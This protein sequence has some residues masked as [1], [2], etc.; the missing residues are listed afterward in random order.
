M[1]A[2]RASVSVDGGAMPVPEIATLDGGLRVVA[3]PMPHARSVAISIY[4]NAGARYEASDADAGLS[5]FLEHLCF[6]G[7]PRRPTPRDVAIEIDALGGLFNAA[8]DRELTVYYG[9]VAADD[10]APALD[11]LADAVQHSLLRDEEIERERRVVLEELAAVEDAPDE[12]ASLALDGLLW[13]DQPIG[14][15]VAGTPASVAAIEPGRIRAYY[16][17]QYVANAAVVAVAGA[18]EPE[19]L[20]GLVQ[21]AADGWAAGSPA[22]WVPARREPGAERVRVVAKETEQAYVSLGV[23]GLD[24]RDDDR[25]ALG[26]L[27]VA[28]GEGMSSRLFMRLREELG[29]CYDVHTSTSFMRDAGA[30]A[31]HAGVDPGNAAA[32]VEEI[33]RQ[34]A[35]VRSS[36][37]AAELA[38][39]KQQVRSRIQLQLEESRA[40]SAWYGTRA[41]LDLPLISPDAA[42][43]NF[44]AVT[45]DDIARVAS[46]LI[47]EDELRLAVVGPIADAGP[48]EERL[49]LAG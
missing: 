12:Q 13:P 3:C 19:A 27:S 15:D 49:R 20:H 18:V 44:E 26:L 33:A 48:L 30:F 23:R 36:I 14:R 11:L 38:R 41:A 7:T 29:L 17:E 25:H 46:R 32:T 43:A 37:D 28:L 10:A 5:H 21:S 45:L 1:V 47:V 9:K 40:V 22:A 34:L 16:R 31:V 39:A 2:E 42:I 8:T 6:K 35:S 24:A 4:I